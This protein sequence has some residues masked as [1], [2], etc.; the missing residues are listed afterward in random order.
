MTSRHSSVSST[1]SRKVK[2]RRTRIPDKPQCSLSLWS[3]MRNCIGKELTK[4]PMPVHFNEPLSVLQRIT[5]DL[6]YANLLD[7]AAEM[8]D[9]CQQMCYVA[10]FATS[11]YSTT[12]VRTTKPFNP[13]L[14]ETY[15]CDRRSDLGWWSF[16][17]QVSHHP[18]SAAHH[19]EGRNWI[20]YQDFTMTSRFRGKYLSI[21]P[22][23][24]T[25]IKFKNSG[26]HYTYKKVTT[27]V[28]N[29]II[30]KLW[31]D[32]H[33]EMHIKN[34]TTDDECQL[35]FHAYSYFSP[36]NAH[37]VTG[38]VKDSEDVAR[39]LLQGF[40]D[41]EIEMAKI[42]KKF[43]SS[44]ETD[45]FKQ[46]WSINPLPEDSEKM[47]RFTKLAIELNEKEDGVAP[48]DSRMRHDQ[49]IMEEGD[50]DKA[51]NVKKEIEEKQRQKLEE[52]S[53]K[54]HF[55]YSPT[56]FDKRQDDVTNSCVYVFKGNYWKCK[57]KQDWSKCP[58][59]F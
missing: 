34:H 23:G 13:V 6:E 3:I 55:E 28:N 54:S 49:R 36:N 19:A 48:T 29:I 11:C 51:N 27:D 37:K 39:Y 46:I 43:K 18:P 5:E 42:T 59:I 53:K 1:S 9:S 38:V 22:T 20:M 25:H 30:G 17:E 32:N 47:Y 21:T 8:T 40:W 2:R 15:E 35:K 44:F 41:K 26:N 57:D 33:G 56:W 16:A 58:S 24:Y 10:A 12:G 14:G 7:L 31:L 50:F 52:Q 4:I 45:T